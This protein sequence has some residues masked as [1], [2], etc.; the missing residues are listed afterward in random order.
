[1]SLNTST[2]EV[3]PSLFFLLY[4]NALSW[5]QI[6]TIYL[7]CGTSAGNDLPTDTKY[8]NLNLVP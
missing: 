7:L 1:M 8:A 5:R 6:K 2:S 4:L 3:L